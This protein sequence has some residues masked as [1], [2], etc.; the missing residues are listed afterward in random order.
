MNTVD[1]LLNLRLDIFWDAFKHLILPV[2]TLAYVNWALILRVMRSSMLE[3]IGQD[4]INVARAKGLTENDVQARHARPNALIPVATV[5]G[6]LL[7]GLLNGAVITETVF[8]YHGMGWWAANAALNLDAV[9]VLGIALFSGMLLIA[10]NLVVDVMYA[11][12]DP[13]IRLS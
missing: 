7:V 13:R 10:A 3:V 2:L 5:G 12:L 4:Y 8:N 6:L 1:A 11:V 9:S